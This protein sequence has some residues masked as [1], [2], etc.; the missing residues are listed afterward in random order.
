MFSVCS[1]RRRRGRE[2]RGAPAVLLRLHHALPDSFL[3]SPLRFRPAHRV[4]EWL[5]LLLR[6]HLP[7][8]RADSRDRGPGLSLRLHR[9]SQRLR[10]RRGVRG[11]RHLSSRW[12]SVGRALFF[13]WV[14]FFFFA[15]AVEAAAW[16]DLCNLSFNLCCQ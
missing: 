1:R 16:G 11:P 10:H 12:A 4:L 2:R 14:F 5:G 3:E 8:R 9:R 13:L 7:Y 6:V 15:R